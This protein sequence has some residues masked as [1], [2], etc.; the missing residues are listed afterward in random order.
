[1]AFPLTPTVGQQHTEVDV[2]YEWSGSSWDLVVESYQKLL[3]NLTDPTVSDFA[4]QGDIWRNTTTGDAWEYSVNY[5]TGIAE[6]V[7]IV[8]DGSIQISA[9]A[10]TTQPDGTPLQFG[11]LWVDSDNADS[12]YY[13]KSPGTWEPLRIYYDNSTANL[14]GSPTTTQTAIDVLAARISVLTKGLSFFGTYN[15][16]T[17]QADFTVSSGLT[18][19][20]LPASGPTNQDSYLVVT[21]AG[22]PATGPLSGTAMSVGDWMISDG[23]AW[24]HLDLS[25]NVTTFT[26]QTATPSVYTGFAGY[27]PVV[28]SAE[29][30]LEFSSSSSDTHSILAASAPT[31]R[32]PPTNT[33]ALQAGDQ[34]VDSNTLNTYVWDGSAWSRIV[35]V[36][37]STSAP[38]QTT[39]GLLWYNPNVSTLYVRDSTINAWVGI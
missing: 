13:Y 14:S 33:A 17:D 27:T 1:M 8:S 10:P 12:T 5:V 11:D 3:E 21:T 36:I 39:G 4:D 26:G 7:K 31:F 15:A 16:A 25:T 6:W 34:W 35:P 2:K 30:A 22:T 28:N 32:D 9:S 20:S 18:D 29:T 37:V 23:T 24:T 19:G 38:T